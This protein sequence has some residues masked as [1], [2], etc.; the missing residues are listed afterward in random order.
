MLTLLQRLE[1]KGFVQRQKQRRGYLYSAAVTQQEYLP[2]ESRTILDR[3]F[4]GSA[5]NFM[6]ALHS[7]D[8]LSRKDIDELQQYLEEL[9]KDM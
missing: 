2:Q 1:A 7:G 5:R 8:A 4:A 6:A 3:L 9:K